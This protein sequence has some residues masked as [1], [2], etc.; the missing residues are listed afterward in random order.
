[1]LLKPLETEK[2]VPCISTFFLGDGIWFVFALKWKFFPF[3]LALENR[4]LLTELS[5]YSDWFGARNEEVSDLFR[6]SNRLYCFCFS[7]LYAA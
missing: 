3:N 5:K 7:R 2:L 6:K 1:M 4:L